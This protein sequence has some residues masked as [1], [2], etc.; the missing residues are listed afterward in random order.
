MSI[1]SCTSPSAS[2]A[3]LPTSQRD[4]RGELALCA[5]AGA[6]RTGAPARRA[7]APARRASAAKRLG[8]GV[9]D[10]ALRSC[11][12][13]GARAARRATLRRS[14]ERTASSSPLPALTLRA[15]GNGA[16]SSPVDARGAS[17]TA[18]GRLTALAAQCG[19]AKREAAGAPRPIVLAEAIG[20]KRVERDLFLAHEALA[21]GAAPELQDRSWR[22]RPPRCVI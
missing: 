4:E 2:C 14:G 7:A 9:D 22:R 19:V 8:G 15:D 17:S 18:R 6:R 10:G 16:G 20:E 21:A 11:G 5:R 3:I 1:I 12:G 13:A